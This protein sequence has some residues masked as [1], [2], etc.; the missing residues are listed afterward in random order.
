MTTYQL[1]PYLI[2]V[3]VKG[4]P[5]ETRAL[6]DLFA[7]GERLEDELASLLA[8]HQGLLLVEPVPK[9]PLRLRIDATG[10][11]LRQL[12]CIVAP[13]RS[14]VESK[15][16]RTDGSELDRG[17]RDIELVPLRHFLTYGAH[18]HRAVLFAERVG[19]AG[20]ITALSKF[21]KAMWA[22]K[23]GNTTLEIA[24]ALSE[25]AMAGAVDSR[26]IKR[27]RLVRAKSPTGDLRVG[28]HAVDCVVDVRPRS[29]GGTW[30]LKELLGGAEAKAS[31]VLSAVSPALYPG[32]TAEDRDALAQQMLDDGWLVAVTIKLEGGTERTVYVEDKS[33]VSMSFAIIEGEL[34]PSVKPTREEFVAACQRVI[35]DGMLSEWGLD[36]TWASMCRWSDVGWTDGAGWKVQWD[37]LDEPAPDR[38]GSV[39]A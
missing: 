38:G 21:L 31:N 1:V 7:G 6:D 23:H 15:I 18:A 8:A 14:G 2:S 24:P 3:H 20:A 39:S 34:A 30:S 28:Q 16:R 19:G 5:T 32:V 26:P 4:K 25:A 37:V 27:F 10:K 12:D 29:R 35:E 33:S 11:G 36:P 13:G 22:S 9:D 17:F